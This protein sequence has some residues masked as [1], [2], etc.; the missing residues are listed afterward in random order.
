MGSCCHVLLAGTFPGEISKYSHLSTSQFASGEIG[1]QEAGVPMCL[2][3]VLQ[4]YISAT[5]FPH[6]RT[7]ANGPIHW[8]ILFFKGQSLHGAILCFVFVCGYTDHCAQGPLL[9]MFG[10]T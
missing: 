7:K 10:G 3:S 6:F 1:E 8:E 4:L 5:C 9:V 2:E